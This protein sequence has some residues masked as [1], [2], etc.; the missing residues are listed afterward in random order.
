MSRTSAL[1]TFKLIG[2]LT[3]PACPYCRPRLPCVDMLSFA[4]DT[5]S[6]CGVGE[7]SGNGISVVTELRERLALLL[8]E[9]PTANAK[10]LSDKPAAHASAHVLTATFLKCLGIIPSSGI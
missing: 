10:V 5:P 8:A 7:A 2:S 1:T 9:A 6:F 3:N 4:G